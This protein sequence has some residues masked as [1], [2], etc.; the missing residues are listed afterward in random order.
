MVPSFPYQPRITGFAPQPLAGTPFSLCFKLLFG[1]FIVFV[2]Q[3]I[4]HTVQLLAW[5]RGKQRPAEIQALLNAAVLVKALVDILLLEAFANSRILFVRR[6]EFLFADDGG[7]R[8]RVHHLGIGGEE[9][10]WRAPS[11]PRAYI[12]RRCVLH[13][14]GRGRAGTETGG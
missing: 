14:D 12:R 1:L 4:V 5:K 3:F 10:G 9:R 7:Q 8:A 6:G 11:G 13:S 2:E